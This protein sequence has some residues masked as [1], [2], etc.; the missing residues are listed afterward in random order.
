MLYLLSFGPS[1][2]AGGNWDR[3]DRAQDWY[4]NAAF[5]MDFT[6][7]TGFS[8]SRYQA[9]ELY[10]DRG[11]RHN[12]T[13]V[14]FYTSRLKWL[15]VSGGQ[16]WGTGINYSPGPGLTPFLANAA[17]SY[18]NITLRPVPRMRLDETYY[19]T[20]LGTRRGYT[21]SGFPDSAAIFNNHLLRT[22]LNY[23]FSKALSLRLI[24]DYFAT[25]PNPTLISDSP[26][27]R[28]TG[29]ILITYLLNTGT[30]LYIGYTDRYDNVALDPTTPPMLR[31]TG[32]P[33][34]S[35]GRQFFIK[36]SYLF[37]F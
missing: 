14:N 13:G 31:P 17:S 36:I 12:T 28:L 35:T 6:G 7:P 32:S 18:G 24:Q 15:S 8:V 22:K 30:A 10:L 27:K 37:R 33:T 4:I 20:R 21:L 29:D 19:Y 2:S 5:A 16:F 23:Q 1:V 25:L 26:F 34:T 9:Y 3:R 11:F